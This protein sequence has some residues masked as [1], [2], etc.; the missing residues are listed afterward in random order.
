MDAR[1]HRVCKSWCWLRPTLNG[2]GRGPLIISEFR[3]R[4]PNGANDEFIEIYNDSGADHT[5][6]GGGTGYAVAASNGVARCGDS[7]RNRNPEPRPLSMRELRWL[8]AGRLSCRQRHD[9]HRRRHLH[10]RHPGQ[11]RHRDLQQHFGA[12]NF[13]LANR[14][15]AVGS[16]RSQHAL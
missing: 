3:V 7:E 5:V 14:F 15:D 1:R 6:A 9:C 11:R 10:D 2:D 8:L 16:T 12:G 4:G 13:T